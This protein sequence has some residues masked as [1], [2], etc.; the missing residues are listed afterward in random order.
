MKVVS[1]LS[2]KGGTGKTTVAIN[3]AVAASLKKKNVVVIDL[4]PQPSA[5]S[6]ADS[7]VAENPVVIS[8]QYARLDNILETAKENKTDLV[9]IDTAPHS[10]TAALAAARVS[11]LVLVPSRPAIFDIRS[12]KDT[13]T[14][15]KLADKPTVAILNA[16]PHQ[17]SLSDEAKQ[18]IEGMGITVCPVQ[19]GQR[20]AF[21]HSLT[22]SQAVQEYE[23]E[24]KAAAEI[25]ELYKWIAER[26]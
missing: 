6:W 1:I 3:L 20:V 19:L 24:G 22:Y 25:L 23:G 7:R 4:D 10:E 12:I 15:T 18:A 16:V 8:A 21:V 2:Q 11:D 26:L 5:S 9:L 14:I 13:I 17:G